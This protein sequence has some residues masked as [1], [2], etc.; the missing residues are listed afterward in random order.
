LA[1][2]TPTFFDELI[3]AA[4]GSFALL[5]GDRKAPTYFDFG[6]RGLVSSF[7]AF[8]IAGAM[9]A[10]GPRLLGFSMESGAA[11]TGLFMSAMLYVLQ[12]GAGWLVLRQFGRLDGFVPYIVTFNWINLFASVITLILLMVGAGQFATILV[13]VAALVVEVNIARLIVT[14]AP[15][16]IVIFIVAKLIIQAVAMGLIIAMVAPDIFMPAVS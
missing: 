2:S 10:Y 5:T 4:Q 8:L 3:A 11:S 14:L 12:A 15:L 16:Q 9:S 1:Q 13:G 7:I 6:Q